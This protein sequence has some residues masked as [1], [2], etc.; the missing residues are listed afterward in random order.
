MFAELFADLNLD[1]EAKAALRQL[2]LDE[3]IEETSLAQY[4][5]SKGD[6]PWNQVAKWRAD[7]RAYLDQQVKGLLSADAYKKWQEY[8]A[9]T[10]DR[11]VES[12]LRNQIKA[13]ASGL[14]DEN[15]ETVMQVAME[16]FR[17]EQSNLDH[18]NTP[19]TTAENLN[20]QIRAMENMRAR[21]EQA[22]PADQFGEIDNWLNMGL[23]MF[24]NQLAALNSQH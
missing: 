20:Y 23:S 13:F 4:A 11:Q 17:T 6:I 18:S 15:F 21:L 24:R 2:L 1:P 5:I 22:L 9:T 7:E 10:D 8:S 14:S 16:E 3:Q 19:F 12:S